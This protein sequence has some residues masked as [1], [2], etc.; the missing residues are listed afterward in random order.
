MVV[1]MGEG[2]WLSGFQKH[3]WG[4]KLSLIEQANLI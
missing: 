4:G 1:K 3:V 2:R